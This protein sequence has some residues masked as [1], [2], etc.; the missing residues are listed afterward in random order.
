MGN[1]AAP[2]DELF[3]HH[4]DMC[5]WSAE[6]DRTQPQERQRDLLQCFFQSPLIGECSVANILSPIYFS[7]LPIGVT[8]LFII[9][10]ARFPQALR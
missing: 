6:R 4:R 7:S 10:G 2:P 5:R 1:P 3:L 9:T 8:A